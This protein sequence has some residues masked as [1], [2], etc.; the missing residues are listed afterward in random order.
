[1]SKIL[2]LQARPAA[3]LPLGALSTSKTWC[4]VAEPLQSACWIIQEPAG[5]PS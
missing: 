5:D 3:T 1:M 4:R 2:A